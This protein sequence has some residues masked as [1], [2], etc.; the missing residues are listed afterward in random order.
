MSVRTTA[1]IAVAAGVFAS[2]T[3]DRNLLAFFSRDAQASDTAALRP[4]PPTFDLGTGTE[5]SFRL[6]PVAVDQPSRPEREAVFP[7]NGTASPKVPRAAARP[8]EPK[9]DDSALRFFASQG[10]RARVAA[11]IRRIRSL[12]PNWQPPEDLFSG[13]QD[14]EVEQRLWDLFGQERY[15]EAVAAIEELQGE[16]PNWRPSDD[17]LAKL[18]QAQARREILSA[19]AAGQHGRV[20]SLAEA[21][22]RLLVCGEMS[23]LW[24]VG[25]ALARTGSEDRAV[26]LYRFILAQC[27]SAPERVA[28]VQK[29]SLLLPETRVVELISL[30]S[31]RPDGAEEFG[32]VRGDL[33]RRRLGEEARQPGSRPVEPAELAAFEKSALEKRHGK[34][35]ELRAW[36][37]YGRKEW[38]L[39]ETWF[40][41]AVSF[42]TNPKGS[43]GLALALRAQGKLIE[44]E[45][46]A[47]E[48]RA[49]DPLLMKLYIEIVTAQLVQREV[50]TI[51]PERLE[52]F[53]KAVIEANSA[54]GLQALGWYS[55]NRGRHAEARDW[56]AKSVAV[57]PYKENILGLALA[58]HRV[59]DR[60][61]VKKLIAEHGSRHP[62]VA[63]IATWDRV[64]RRARYAS[65]EGPGR[66]K[67][68]GRTGGRT[69]VENGPDLGRTA[70]NLYEEGQYKEAIETLN[71]R[72]AKRKEEPYLG[73]VRGWALYKQGYYT[74]A[75]D[76][77]RAMDRVNSTRDTQYGVFY[78]N[79]QLIPRQF[80]VE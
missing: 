49:A 14:R 61:T 55:F 78:S 75:R 51:E 28:T 18:A 32:Q 77:F 23:V 20:L 63:S 21:Q 9:V 44:A 6:V 30:G 65:V 35:A 2:P 5:P 27:S 10:D 66:G 69:P 39:A 52:R 43:E 73:I 25:E 17:L 54:V 70:I 34:D 1:L 37:S 47:F 41:H 57:E 46:V 13:S 71:R 62:E 29:A 53:S 22:P 60:A 58:S 72:A 42:E 15:D 4:R 12:H 45:T 31:R 59:K 16:R 24:A 11:E 79:E 56:F 80:R 68:G 26:G 67:R 3:L 74:Q 33:L 64:V 8:A 36:Y 19:A 50:K 38:V 76:H 48:S 40:R 7:L